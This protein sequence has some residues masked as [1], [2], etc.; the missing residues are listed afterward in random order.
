MLSTTT[1]S[2]ASFFL[3]ALSTKGLFETLNINDIQHKWLT[4]MKYVMLGCRYAECRILFV[5]MLNVVMLNVVML[6]AV[7]AKLLFSPLLEVPRHSVKR[8]TEE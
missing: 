1:L 3:M 4:N 7:G 5:V 6:S 8:H 2:I